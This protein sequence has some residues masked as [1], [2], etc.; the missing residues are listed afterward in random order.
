M[1][2]LSQL[3]PGAASL[4]LQTSTMAI[5]RPGPAK[6]HP[7]EENLPKALLR[8]LSEGV[9][10]VDSK[11]ETAV[12]TP[13]AKEILGM[14]GANGWRA[15]F[16]S[17]PPALVRITTEVAATEKDPQVRKV[18]LSREGAAR[19][20]EVTA[21][22]LGEKPGHSQV[23][24]VLNEVSGTSHF[25]DHVERLN[26][27]ASL[28]TLAA[29]MAHEIKNALVAGKTFIDLLLERQDEAE[30][31]Q[32]V[33][34]ELGRIDTMVSRMLKF[35]SPPEIGFRKVHLH[36]VLDYSLRLVEP[37]METKP[38]GHTKAF[39]ATA[40]LVEGDEHELQQA[41]VN[42]LLNAIDAVGPSGKVVVGTQVTPADAPSGETPAGAQPPWLEITI[43]DTG[44]GI[45]PENMKRLFEPFFTTKPSG[46]GLGLAI[47]RRIVQQHH[48]QITAAS[49]VGEGTT[50]TIQLPIAADSAA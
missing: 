45:A 11:R 26:R 35:A 50:F 21:V 34:R 42:L 19:N 38:L 43:Q 2:M 16:E 9:V 28:G 41:F 36:E 12:V 8:C 47:T 5:N 44:M 24:L 32:V 40:D 23:M 6:K 4:I 48:G 13:A 30:F 3:Q 29:S 39:A 7:I 22:A 46:T 17:L 1:V 20:V 18:A 33:R 27:L 37:L 15:P 10:L 49:R 31:A 14:R 25:E